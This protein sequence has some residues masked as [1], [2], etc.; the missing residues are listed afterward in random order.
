MR[1]EAYLAVQCTVPT[2]GGG[3]P[4]VL[5]AKTRSISPGG[6]EIFLPD[7]LP[8]RT[9]VLIQIG[10][11]VPLRA[12][13]VS[14]QAAILTSVGPRV[15]HGVE[16]ERPVDPALVR[17]WVYL[18]ER[19][20]HTRAPARF[21]VQY[22]QVGV[23]AKGTCLNLSRGGM[24]IATPRPASPG[25]QVALTFNLPNVSHTFSLLARVVWMRQEERVPNAPGGM[26]VQFLDPKPAESVLI[27]G[28]VD[29][30]SQ[31]ASPPPR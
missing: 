16:F 24:F 9:P 29:R 5:T 28:V 21:P 19:Q 15:P 17:Q 13:V 31:Q 4:T 8:L 18:G 11:G 12:Q 22:K 20:A 30:L 14:L 10:E 26:G 23:A 3:P 25:S 7:A 1:S 27:G 6:L 2:A